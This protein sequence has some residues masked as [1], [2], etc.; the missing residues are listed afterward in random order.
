V[1]DFPTRLRVGRLEML[2]VRGLS[3][4]IPAISRFNFH[5]RL[6]QDLGAGRRSLERFDKAA[7]LK[8]R[9]PWGRRRSL[10]R[11]RCSALGE[12]PLI[13]SLFRGLEKFAPKPAISK[14]DVGQ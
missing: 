6:H 13:K 3:V 7:S 12:G 14:D 5:A 10:R 9:E 2:T 8:C 1:L 4:V 11:V